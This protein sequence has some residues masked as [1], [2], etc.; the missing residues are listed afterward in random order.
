VLRQLARILLLLAHFGKEG[1]PEKVIPR[2]SQETLAEKVGTTRSRVNFFTNRFRRS[3]FIRY[4]GRL[5]VHSSLLNV[6]LRDSVHER[7]G[8]N[9]ARAAKLA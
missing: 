8:S 6:V 2:I 7:E 5:E 3:G 9:K 4:N 1:T